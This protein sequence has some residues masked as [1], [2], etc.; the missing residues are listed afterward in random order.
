MAWRGV[1][2]EYWDRLPIE[3]EKAVVTLLEGGTPLITSR[4]L[5]EWIGR[6]V[7]IYFKFEGINPTGSFKDRGMTVA[8]S[9]A[10]EE[11]SKAVI[12]ASTGNTSAAAAAYAVRAGLK[13]FVL[14][15]EGKI[16]RGK[17]GQA[18]AAALGKKCV[19]VVPLPRPLVRLVG[20]CG[21]AME[22]IRR[23]PGW[24]NRDKMT[25]ALA[26]SWTCSSVKAH[27]HLGWLP[28]A[29]LAD[30]LHETAHWYRHTKWL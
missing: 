20:C 27:T 16:A 18:M 29:T 6:K 12:C 28:A 15:P 5:P 4:S 7:K 23:R 10:V 3:D 1:V 11:G 21:N 14:I 24:V 17:L 25:E 30:R 8:V 19:I 22:W 2:R 9:R 13:A 26:G